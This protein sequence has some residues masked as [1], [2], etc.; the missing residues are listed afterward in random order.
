MIADYLVKKDFTID[1]FQEM[2]LNENLRFF[3]GI[4]HGNALSSNADKIYEIYSDLIKKNAQ[5]INIS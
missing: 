4:T 3:R 2:T 5:K 1:N